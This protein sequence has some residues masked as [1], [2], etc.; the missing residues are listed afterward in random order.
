MVTPEGDVFLAGSLNSSVTIDDILYNTENGSAGAYYFAR[1]SS[2]GDLVWFT[3]GKGIFTGIEMALG[4]DGRIFFAGT[5]G[6][7]IHFENDSITGPGSDDVLF[8]AIGQD[9]NL[10]WWQTAGHP[11]YIEQPKGLALDQNNNIYL[12]FPNFYWVKIGDL[13]VDF[14]GVADQYLY[15]FNDQGIFQWM[16]PLYSGSVVV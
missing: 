11:S 7:T 5:A 13:Q 8:G 10:L 2:A 16:Q 4:T 3:G 6:N 15:K 9:G 12:A 14:D 1:F